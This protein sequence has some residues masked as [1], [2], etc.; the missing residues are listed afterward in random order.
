V[1][2]SSFLESD[3]GQYE[4][5]MARMH[6]F[7]QNREILIVIILEDMSIDKMPPRLQ[8]IWESITCLE[9]DDTVRGCSNPDSSHL[10]WKRLNQAM[11]V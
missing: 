7:R 3:Y 2:S 11:S 6:M 10:F 1:I 4:L 8:Q 5:N 9:A